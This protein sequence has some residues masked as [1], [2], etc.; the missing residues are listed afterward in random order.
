MYKLR[1]IAQG[2]IA[3]FVA[4]SAAVHFRGYGRVPLFLLLLACLSTL[5]LVSCRTTWLPFL[6]PSAMPVSVFRPM[7]PT[8]PELEITLSA[9]SD[10]VRV[11]YWASSIAAD[12]PIRAYGGYSNAGVADVTEDGI[13][14]LYIRHPQPYSVGS[15]TLAPHVHYRWISA[16]GMLTGI[17][18]LAV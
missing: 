18:T 5:W 1:I 7:T 11:V 15:T 17:K 12:D 6:G 4:V 14:T 10:A 13:A 9:P 8:D 16:R 2:I 3:I